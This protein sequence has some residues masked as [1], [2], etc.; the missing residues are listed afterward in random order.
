MKGAIVRCDGSRE[1]GH[2]H[3][4]R[5]LVLASELRRR[6]WTITYVT[7]DLEGAPLDRMRD[8]GFEIESLPDSLAEPDDAD[9]TA[10]AAL[11]REAAW[12]VVDRYATGPDAHALWTRRGLR[13]LAID[14]ICRHPFP[15]DVLLN[16]NT[17]AGDLPYRTGPDTERLFGPGF[18]LIRGIYRRLRPSTPRRIASVGR[19]LVFMG[20]GDPGDA[21][22]RIAEA[23]GHAGGSLEIT[24]VVGSAYPHRATLD[25]TAARIPHR[26]ST[27]CDLPD[28]AGPI[29]RADLAVCAGGS[30][31]WE[32]CCMGVPA[33]IAPFADNQQGIAS[34]MNRTT[35]TPVI[36]RVLEKSPRA[37]AAEIAP[38]I[39]GVPELETVARR[40]WNLVDGRGVERVA[41]RLEDDGGSR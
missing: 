33:V 10:D 24:V 19:V 38:V 17:D 14:D 34:S 9:A 15:V 18:A 11:R 21:T 8:A 40:A 30:V 35:G 3:V 31:T 13:V 23:L 20:G 1:L 25:A 41:D 12:I 5:T 27:F 32:L 16:Q 2:G 6:G 7:R 26:V 39:R 22:G 36:E 4:F 29:A 28:L 37:I